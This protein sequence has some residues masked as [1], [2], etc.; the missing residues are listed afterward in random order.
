MIVKMF[1]SSDDDPDVLGLLRAFD[2]EEDRPLEP[3][4]FEKMLTD[5]FGPGDVDEEK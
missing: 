3:G 1:S 5:A 4:E 2:Q